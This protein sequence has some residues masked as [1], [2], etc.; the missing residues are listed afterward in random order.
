[1]K[2]SPGSL[3]TPPLLFGPQLVPVLKIGQLLVLLIGTARQE[4]H[5][6]IGY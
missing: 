5:G 4:A 2:D 6:N 3:T 1:M